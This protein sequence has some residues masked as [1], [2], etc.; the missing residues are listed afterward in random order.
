MSEPIHL[1]VR[2]LA[3]FLLQS[4][5]IDNRF[6]GEERAAE[7]SRIH[8]RL[9]KEAGPDYRPELPLSLEITYRGTNYLLEGRADGVF[10]EGGVPTVDEIKT[11][12][13]PIELIS[14]SF[15]A[16]H[17]GQARCYAYI[18]SVT[19]Q[20]EQVGVQL[21]Y[22]QVDTGEIK[23]FCR[24]E[25]AA[26]LEAFLYALLESYQKW[27]RFQADWREARTASIQGL[28][29]PFAAYR[30]GQREM[31]VAVYRAVQRG[32]RLFCQAPTGIGKTISTLFPSVKAMGE[33]LAERIF[34][35]TAKTITRQAAEEA[36]TLLRG[37]GLRLKTITLTAKDKICFLEERNCNPEACPYADG[38]YDRARDGVFALLTAR[39][40][41]TREQLEATAREFRI[42]PFELSLDLSLW[43][44][45]IICDYNYLFDP[46]AGLQR[47]FSGKRG[48]FI[49]LVD[50]AHNLVERA[51]DMYS[52]PLCKS[53]FSA[54]KTALGKGG[55]ELSRSLRA[56][57]TQM[58]SI[59]KAC[60]EQ[61]FLAEEEPN[62]AFCEAAARFSTAASAWLEEH[63]AQNPLRRQ[64][65]ER[66]FEASFFLRILELFDSHYRAFYT[67][68]KNEVTAKLLCLDTSALLDE[69]LA[70]GRCAVFFSATLSPLS[71]YREVLG[72]GPEAKCGALLSPFP[73]KN[74]CLLCAER[75]STKYN[76]REKSLAPIA[77]LLERFVGAKRGNY[78]A[79]FPSYRYL[80][81]V[82]EV[83]HE[84]CPQVE[85]L[86]QTGKMDEA[87]REAFLLRFSGENEATLLGFCVLGGIFAEG[88]DMKEDRLIGTAIVG[89]GLPQLGPELDLLRD[90]YNGKGGTGYEYAYRYP[91]MNK[92]LQAAGRVI[93]GPAERGAVLLIDSRFPTRNYRALFPPHWNHCLPVNSEE[94]LVQ[95]L[96][97]FWDVPE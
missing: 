37:G 94:A 76:D 19:E 10:P 62:K 60:G 27:A 12:G 50:E 92:V 58:I 17:W 23:R 86:V 51:R 52:A 39:D 41:F 6:G 70:K 21:T 87:A 30:A 5:S 77:R 35:L 66:Y 9:Q 65:L 18:L 93:R 28:A 25:S 84:Q 74:L 69:R 15:N 89:V 71:Y 2:E 31:A 24:M 49:F 63:K 95:S 54:L 29:F 40:A 97:A 90:Y 47:Y 85:T 36:Y 78:M 46:V 42:C 81:E 56:L 91:G 13:V 26:S 80:S 67:A 73:Q 7:G 3:E 32:E 57:N 34:Y 33:G 59:R 64:V 61:G 8:R 44:D 20:L 68:Q 14:E 45:G 43:C 82:Y 4:G 72:G 83:F 1:A 53:S 48:E 79:Y 38:Y 22:Y 75:V 88:V 16:A 11:T 96:A 55:G